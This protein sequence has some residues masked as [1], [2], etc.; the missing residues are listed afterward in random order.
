MCRVLQLQYNTLVARQIKHLQYYGLSVN[1][2]EVY[3]LHFP[4]ISFAM[5]LFK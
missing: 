3:A 1:E 4:K 5:R 2:E